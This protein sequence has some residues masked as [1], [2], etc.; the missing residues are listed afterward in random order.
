MTFT[1][2]LPA[3]HHLTDGAPLSLRVTDATHT[4]QTAT[5]SAP[6]GD[7]ATPTVMAML[8]PEILAA[9]PGERYFTVYY[10]HCS[11]GAAAVCTPDKASWKITPTIDSDAAAQLE[12]EKR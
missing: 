3:G 7:S 4:L 5:V 11:S 1:L 6:A 10:T 8:S 9:K 2:A 12:L